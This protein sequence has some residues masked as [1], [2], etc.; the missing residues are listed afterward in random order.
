V[1]SSS[2]FCC[3]MRTTQIIT[4]TVQLCGATGTQ[5]CVTWKCSVGASLRPRTSFSFLL[6]D[7]HFYKSTWL[8]SSPLKLSSSTAHTPRVLIC[9]HCYITM[10]GIAVDVARVNKIPTT[11]DWKKK[12][13]F[14][15]LEVK[16][17]LTLEQPTKARRGSRGIAL[18][19]L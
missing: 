5:L 9:L 2:H 7:C 17:K 10:F 19:F 14:L 4:V 1:Q 12:T 3:E 8:G 16:L 15:C 18:L 6:P 13:L 11:S